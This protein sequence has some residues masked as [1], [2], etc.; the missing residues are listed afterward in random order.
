[1][2]LRKQLKDNKGLFS[3]SQEELTSLREKVVTPQGNKVTGGSPDMAKMAGTPAQTKSAIRAGIE[4]AENLATFQRR[5]GMQ[6]FKQET[7]DEVGARQQAEKLAGLG[8]LAQSLPDLISERFSLDT[9]TPATL[10]LLNTL[11]LED[12]DLEN[13]IRTNPASL[14]GA[15]LVKLADKL[16]VERTPEMSDD[17]FAQLVKSKLNLGDK[18][19]AEKIAADVAG[20]VRIA[21][22]NDADLSAMGFDS[23]ADMAEALEV[24]EE[25]LQGMTLNDIE[26]TL[27]TMQADMF[28]QA[29]EARSIIANPNASAAEKKAAQNALKRFSKLGIED[30]EVQVSDI[31]RQIE[32]GKTLEFDGQIVKLDELLDSAEVEVKVMEALMNEDKMA[33]LEDSEPQLFNLVQTHKNAFEAM[34]GDLDTQ[35]S[36]FVSLNEENQAQAAIQD[37]D[38]ELDEDL[39]NIIHGFDG[40]E[41]SFSDVRA[42]KLE[43]PP[44]ITYLNDAEIP[45]EARQS[46][47]YFL[48]EIDAGNH[49]ELQ[50]EVRGLTVDELKKLGFSRPSD[51]SSYIDKYKKTKQISTYDIQTSSGQNKF[52][53]DYLGGNLKNLKNKLQTAFT[54]NS[55]GFGSVNN[56]QTKILDADGDGKLDPLNQVIARLKKKGAT[57]LR[58]L[59]NSNR[60][61]ADA[62]SPT[63]A[64]FSVSEPTGTYHKIK[65]YYKDGRVNLRESIE[66][67]NKLNKNELEQ[68]LNM[69]GKGM[70]W[71]EKGQL[72]DKLRQHGQARAQEHYSWHMQQP[73]MP[74]IP[75]GPYGLA[76][77]K[78]NNVNDLFKAFKAIE[79]EQER[80]RSGRAGGSIHDRR[81]WLND[82]SIK[83]HQLHVAAKWLAKSTSDKKQLASDT[84]YDQAEILKIKKRLEKL[85]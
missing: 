22:L 32:E 49:K 50:A 5:G 36:D 35:I 66:I 15:D 82:H 29:A 57:S 78:I 53:N 80:I 65:D 3:T 8:Q 54:I 21:E 84:S 37:L 76:K 7:A 83:K 51:V 44:I 28:D 70:G 40:E 11:E 24:R 30:V 59:L 2:S 42:D 81:V 39:M 71:R 55:S 25:D 58:D 79:N 10:D 62:Q 56:E 61:L 26:S 38:I 31:Q 13:K 1:M 45:T 85:R 47:H 6:D 64:A 67:S 14:T 33:E 12:P 73:G 75:D 69:G 4:G 74:P 9:V 41:Q 34:V 19:L 46:M 52:A 20:E 27:S 63:L 23:F 68:L 18:N 43:E 60:K 72:K 16:D 48:Q 77:M 17:Q